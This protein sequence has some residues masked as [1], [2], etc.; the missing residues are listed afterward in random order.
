MEYFRL[1]HGHREYRGRFG[2]R[3]WGKIA[4]N[5]ITYTCLFN[6]KH[7]VLTQFYNRFSSYIIIL[8][9]IFILYLNT[10][11]SHK[12]LYWALDA[13]V[14]VYIVVTPIYFITIIYIY[15]YYLEPKFTCLYLKPVYYL[16]IIVAISISIYYIKCIYYYNVGKRE[17]LHISLSISI[18]IIHATRRFL[19]LPV[20]INGYRLRCP[21]K[22]DL[23]KNI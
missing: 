14:F 21:S 1:Y 2:H 8:F 6:I 4:Y 12:Y 9:S 5:I 10:I 15:N 17:F 3:I 23:L 13:S 11:Y 20:F 19:Y 16:Q 7:I 22:N 18:H